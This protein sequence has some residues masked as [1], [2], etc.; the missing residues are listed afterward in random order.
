MVALVPITATLRGMIITPA[1]C[2][3]A[4]GLVAW[5]QD[6]LAKRAGVGNSTVRDFEKGRRVP[7]D[8]NLTTIRATLEVAGVVFENDGK[9]V[10]VKLKIRRGK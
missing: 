5:S 1:Q 3:A 7:M 6:Q 10:G 9:H 2:R 8:D 4:R